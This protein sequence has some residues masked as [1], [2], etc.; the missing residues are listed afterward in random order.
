VSLLQGSFSQ[1][2]LLIT[3]KKAKSPF[4]LFGVNNCYK[5]KNVA[6]HKNFVHHFI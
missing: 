1:A 4:G 6:Q 2:R 5:I 3:G